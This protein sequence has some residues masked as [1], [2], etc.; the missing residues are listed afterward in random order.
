MGL[1]SLEFGVFGVEADWPQKPNRITQKW[2]SAG[3]RVNGT[4]GEW[5]LG[6]PGLPAFFPLKSAQLFQK[7]GSGEQ[8]SHF[9]HVLKNFGQKI[10][11]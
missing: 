8:N 7:R 10:K 2:R 1:E 9:F 3:I 5:S 11:F 6:D 4:D